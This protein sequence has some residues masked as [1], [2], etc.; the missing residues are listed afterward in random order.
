MNVIDERRPAFKNRWPEAENVKEPEHYR[1]DFSEDK[2]YFVEENGT[3]DWKIGDGLMSVDA[4]V[5][6]RLTYLH[7]Y[8]KNVTLKLRFRMMNPIYGAQLHFVLRYNSPESYVKLKYLFNDKLWGVYASEGIDYPVIKYS[9]NFSHPLTPDEWYELCFTVDGDKAV[10]YLN[11]ELICEVSGLEKL[12]PGRVALIARN[13]RMEV[14]DFDA[15]FLSGQGTLWKNCI[16]NKLPDEKYREGGSV[17]EMT[18]GSLIYTHSSGDTF[19]SFDNGVTWNRREQWTN[20]YHY[21]NILRLANGDFLK[22]CTKRLADEL[23]YKTVEL[24]SDDGKTWRDGGTICLGLHRGK[25]GETKG[26]ALNM[27]DKVTQTST[28]RIFYGQNFDSQGSKEK[29]YG[30]YFVLCEIFYSDDNGMTWQRSETPTYEIEGCKD[31]TYFGECK[32]LECADGS[33]RIYNSWNGFGCVVYSESFDGGVTWGP[34]KRMPEL[35]CARSSMQFFRDTYADND[36]TYYMLWV[37]SA[38]ESQRSDSPMHRSRLSLARSY[39]GKTW[40]FLGDIW[41]WESTYMMAADI[42]HAVD[43]FVKTTKDYVICGAGFSERLEVEGAGDNS[44]H[45]A[46]RQHIYSIPKANLTDGEMKPV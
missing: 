6:G 34:I 17:F 40:A 21:P 10:G 12:S 13:C 1:D 9:Q 14:A 46:Q 18:D 35:V 39:D 26:W 41:R 11:G 43:A 19:D 28:G 30:K 42:A 27:N 16:H 22:V 37:Y 5:D 2:G 45:H 36:T 38:P 33:L 44:Y 32:V 29:M 3:K 15:A 20:T 4:D 24:S 25:Y 8:E 31:E 23:Q 7:I